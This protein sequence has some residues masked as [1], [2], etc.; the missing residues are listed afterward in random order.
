MKGRSNLLN[1]GEGNDNQP[2]Y[3]SLEN[4]MVREG[5]QATVHRVT[6]TDMTEQLTHTLH[7]QLHRHSKGAESLDCEPRHQ[8]QMLPPLFYSSRVAVRPL[9]FSLERWENELMVPT[10]CN[11]RPRAPQNCNP[12]D[13]NLG[14]S[15]YS[16]CHFPT[17]LIALG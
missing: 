13:H 6:E 5:W 1:H 4:P 10:S 2:Q 11:S 17:S 16:S 15:P 9:G 8:L 14:N 12:G 7:L 3:S